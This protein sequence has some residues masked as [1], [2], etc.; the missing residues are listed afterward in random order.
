MQ[1][2]VSILLLTAALGALTACGVTGTDSIRVREAWGRPSPSSAT[3]AA[4]Y[5]R[6]EN[7]GTVADKLIGAEIEICGQSELHETRIDENGVMRMSQVAEIL[8]PPG[9]EISLEPGGYHVMCLDR[10]AELKPGDQIPITLTLAELGEVS[11]RAEIR[12]R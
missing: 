9:Q 12:E 10:S 3:N 5:M 8:I 4:F 2:I 11:I 1:K 6:L 7:K